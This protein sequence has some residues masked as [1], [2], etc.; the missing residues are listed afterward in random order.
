MN[1]L[2]ERKWSFGQIPTDILDGR[3]TDHKGRPFPTV[4][5]E[6]LSTV[7]EEGVTFL[8]TAVDGSDTSIFFHRWLLDEFLTNAIDHGHDGNPSKRVDVEISVRVIV[9]DGKRRIFSVLRVADEGPP[10]NP[11][12]IK[13]PTDAERAKE[14]TGRGVHGAALLAERFYGY[15]P[16]F[17]VEPTV[18]PEGKHS[19]KRVHFQWYREIQIDGAVGEA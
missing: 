4:L 12:D 10:F 9:E 5:F 1:D 11:G 13:D 8:S 18:F 7:R 2:V 15:T 3:T 14:P 19:G 16:T 17:S 6:E